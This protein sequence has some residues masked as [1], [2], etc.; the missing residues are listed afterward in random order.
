MTENI[1]SEQYGKSTRGLSPSQRRL[2]QRER[3]KYSR[4]D[5]PED[6][7]FALKEPEQASLYVPNY[8]LSG[9]NRDTEYHESILQ[10][11]QDDIT[12]SF[13]RIRSADSIL[14]ANR[15]FENPLKQNDE[16]YINII[17]N[18]S[19][20]IYN[21]LKILEYITLDDDDRGHQFI[22]DNKQNLNNTRYYD[23][24]GGLISEFLYD[25]DNDNIDDEIITAESMTENINREQYGKSTRG[26][27]PSQRRLLQRERAKY[28]RLDLPEDQYFTGQDNQNNNAKLYHGTR[29][30]G[31]LRCKDLRE[32]FDGLL[33]LHTSPTT[34]SVFSKNVVVCDSNLNIDQLHELPDI[35]GWHPYH[36]ADEFEKLEI[37]S[38]DERDQVLKYGPDNESISSTERDELRMQARDILFT[39]LNNKN[40]PAFKYKNKYEDVY[41]DGF[42][43]AVIDKS[44]LHNPDTPIYPGQGRD[45]LIETS[46]AAG[47]RFNPE[48][49][50]KYS[51]YVY[52]DDVQ[53]ED[54]Y[55]TDQEKQYIK[56]PYSYELGM[57]TAPEDQY[58]MVNIHGVYEHNNN[59]SMPNV[60]NNK[61][62]NNRNSQE[63]YNSSRINN[64]HSKLNDSQSTHLSNIIEHNIKHNTPK[65]SLQSR[66]HKLFMP[67]NYNRNNKYDEEII[68]NNNIFKRKINDS[69]IKQ[70]VMAKALGKI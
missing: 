41:K 67:Q 62:E 52:K 42:S 55:I 34:T 14:R 28:S 8:I 6:Q 32:S 54:Q 17:E 29:H 15:D 58:L 63:K 20:S 30:F 7:Y 68:I 69:Y 23:Q 39:I 44:V 19:E 13:D 61:L 1:N 27:S 18:N 40:I 12:R 35:L 51:E 64:I 37:I 25:N 46:T 26:L 3:A 22:K 48:P 70:G 21:N 65:V 59:L 4:L 45:E 66:N 50:F 60:I 16:P 57:Y 43:I 36:I 9:I 10:R 11:T 2:L 33:H 5:L 53:S 47:E 49:P 24:S 38:E 56:G 31:L